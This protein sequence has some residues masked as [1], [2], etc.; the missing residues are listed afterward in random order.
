[1]SVSTIGLGTDS[2]DREAE[3]AAE[4]QEGAG[5][6]HCTPL[7]LGIYVNCVVGPK[8]IAWC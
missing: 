5:F 7:D 3:A 8:R 2:V 1:M 6:R 4:E